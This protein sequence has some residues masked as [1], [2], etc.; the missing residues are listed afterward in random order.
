MFEKLKKS[1]LFLPLIIGVFIRLILM[2]TTYHVDLLGHSF[3][4]Y[5]F[6]YESKLNPY[7][8]LAELPPNH[9]LVKNYGIAD[10]FIY[11]PITYFTLGIF[12]ILIKPFVD[13][14]FFPFLMANPSSIHS[15][16]DLFLNLFLFKLPYL[17]IDTAIGF[18]LAGL[19][20][21]RKKKNV[22]FWLWMLNP[23]TLYATFMIGQ[24]DI[25]AVFFTVLALHFFK[26]NKFNW[27][28]IS[29]GIGGAYK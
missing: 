18:L 3:T 25:M 10:I 2:P 26:Q 27:M 28:L 1:G 15:R 4:A 9:P 24:V 23:V 20:D 13:P 12:R 8:A 17:F 16:P 7:E 14:N 22:A 19:F 11:P 29:L 6:A 21:D 5:F